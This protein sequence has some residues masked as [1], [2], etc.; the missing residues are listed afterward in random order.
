MNA[1][2]TRRG[3]VKWFDFSKKYGFVTLEGEEDAMLHLSCL[4]QIKV[5]DA[6]K[7]SAVEVVVERTK[8]GLSVKRV[9]SLTPQEPYING[10]D[11]VPATV[12]WFDAERGYGFVTRGE[13]TDDV[14]IHAVT[15]KASSLVEL[16]P[17]QKV[18]IVIE[19]GK[20]GPKVA[21]IKA[22]ALD[23]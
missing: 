18:M 14:F 17:D 8:R 16:K 23:A 2:E 5:A 9:I 20:N 1:Q 7:G 21:H 15:V 19:D 13:G 4:Q 6:P 10:N 12:K 3:T 22:V 11:Y